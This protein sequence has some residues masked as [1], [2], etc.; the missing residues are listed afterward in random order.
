MPRRPR[1][2]PPVR[3]AAELLTC[4]DHN[5]SRSTNF[6]AS[7]VVLNAA[8]RDL[9]IGAESKKF[10]A[11]FDYDL[12]RRIRGRSRTIRARPPCRAAKSASSYVASN[13]S[14]HLGARF[15]DLKT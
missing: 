7:E 11:N 4:F 6:F 1:A 9:S 14:R 5:S 12:S 8:R 13:S 2:Q 10:T 3:R 15:C